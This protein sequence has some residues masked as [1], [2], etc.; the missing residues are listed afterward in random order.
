M[1]RAL[2]A[3]AI[4]INHRL[5]GLVEHSSHRRWLGLLLEWGFVAL[6]SVV[7]A[8]WCVRQSRRARGLQAAAAPDAESALAMRSWE[9]L[10]QEAEEAAQ[11]QRWRDAVRGYYWAAIARFESR[12]QWAAD[13]ARTPREYMRLV[14]PGHPKHDDLQLLTRRFETCW[15][16]SDRATQPDCDAARQLFERLAAR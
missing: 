8:F 11:Q 6:A 5:A 1:Q 2:E 15:Y 16:G 4:W 14:L 12:G 7:L 9:R 13:R 10:R 3:V